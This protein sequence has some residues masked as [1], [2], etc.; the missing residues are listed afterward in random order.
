MTRNANKIL[1]WRGTSLDTFL[2]KP[3]DDKIKRAN[4]VDKKWNVDKVIVHWQFGRWGLTP[5]R[6]R[7]REVEETI[8]NTI[9]PMTIRFELVDGFEESG[10]NF[11]LY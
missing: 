11:W 4:H 3:H 1:L 7:I 2:I 8:L 6:R 9:H 5:L 10:I